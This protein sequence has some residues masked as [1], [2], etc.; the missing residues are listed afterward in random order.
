MS[1]NGLDCPEVDT[2]TTPAGYLGTAVFVTRLVI[3]KRN[4]TWVEKAARFLLPVSP[5]AYHR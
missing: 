3:S 4:L 2:H 1:D 5:A